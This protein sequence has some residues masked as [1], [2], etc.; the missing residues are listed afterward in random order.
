MAMKKRLTHTW[1]F[2]KELHAEWQADG[3]FQLA[4]ALS[5]YTVFSIAPMFAVI[6]TVAGYFLGTEAVTGELYAQ[7]QGYI[8]PQSAIAIQSMVESIN[9]ESNSLLA[10]VVGGAMLLFS[11]SAAFAALQNALNKIYKVKVEVET[12]AWA[13]V[14]NRLLSFVMVL[15]IGFLLVLSLMLDIVLNV[16]AD[17]AQRIGEL[18]SADFRRLLGLPAETDAHGPLIRHYNLALCPD[19]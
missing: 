8:G 2:L 10:T 15:V 3:C 19:I 6:I 14:L 9:Q 16:L 13:V 5:Y 18:C 4:A 1:R 7:I 12:N 11:A 17:Y